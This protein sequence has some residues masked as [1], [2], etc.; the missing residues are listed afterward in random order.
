MDPYFQRLVLQV[1]RAPVRAH[2]RLMLMDYV[3]SVRRD[4]LDRPVN[5]LLVI[6]EMVPRRVY[7]PQKLRYPLVYALEI[8]IW[9]RI[10]ESVRYVRLD[11][12]EHHVSISVR[13]AVQQLA[14]ERLPDNRIRIA[15]AYLDL[16]RIQIVRLVS[17]DT[18]V[19]CVNTSVRMVVHLSI[20]R[21]EPFLRIRIAVVRTL[22]LFKVLI[23]RIVL[24]VIQVV[25]VGYVIYQIVI[26]ALS[27]LIWQHRDVH[28]IQEQFLV[29]E[30]VQHAILLTMV[31]HANIAAFLVK[32]VVH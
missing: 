3:R 15:D 22:T 19:H 18:L 28:V 14:V 17:L 13:T 2:S 29:T 31:Q 10:Q 32:M 8:G 25:M 27:Y 7:P 30:R 24:L 23:V 26:L 16:F 12:L 4:T 1:H 21:V 20:R 5:L 6:V 9:I 11:T